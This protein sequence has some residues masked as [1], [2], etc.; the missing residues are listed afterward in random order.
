MSDSL[1]ILLANSHSRPY[2]VR[3]RY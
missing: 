1:E 2:L 3:S